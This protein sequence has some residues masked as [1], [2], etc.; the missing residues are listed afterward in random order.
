MTTEY[1]GFSIWVYRISG[2]YSYT[3]SNLSDGKYL[4]KGYWYGKET[5]RQLIGLMTQWIDQYYLFPKD[6]EL[7]KEGEEKCLDS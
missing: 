3:I 7:A 4:T 6:F 1:R 2:Y 5:K